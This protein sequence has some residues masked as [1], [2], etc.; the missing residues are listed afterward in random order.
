MK[1]NLILMLRTQEQKVSNLIAMKKIISVLVLGF[2][3]LLTAQE[4]KPI[5]INIE[6]GIP[7][8]SFSK[9][10]FG[11]EFWIQEQAK[12]IAIDEENTKVIELKTNNGENLLKAHQEAVTKYKDYVDEQAKK[13]RYKFSSRSESL[14]DFNASKSL[15]DTLGFKLVLDSWAIPSKSTLSVN[16]LIKVTYFVPKAKVDSH[17]KT[18]NIKALKGAKII[19]FNGKEVDLK[20]NYSS[21]YNGDRFL[22]YELK[23]QDLG[24]YVEKIAHV[25]NE[26]KVIDNLLKYSADNKINF[27]V[28]ESLVSTPI[29]LKFTFKPLLRKSVEIKQEV[30]IGL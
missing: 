20:Q 2:S 27:D 25:D 3:F 4:V 28:K 9:T 14:I 1:K 15:K 17:T 18:I 19:N 21:R 22:G 30:N 16:C 13:G 24:V 5:K 29:N 23:T 11:L 26:G 12:V 7:G 10:T 6:Q 8:E